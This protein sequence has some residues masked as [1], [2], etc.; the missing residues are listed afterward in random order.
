M[1]YSGQWMQFQHIPLYVGV[2]WKGS[3]RF[4]FG[5]CVSEV[6]PVIKILGHVGTGVNSTSSLKT[7]DIA[8]SNRKGDSY[9]TLQ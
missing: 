1:Q 8:I 2:P 4:V 3:G 7:A 9:I 6:C 5:R